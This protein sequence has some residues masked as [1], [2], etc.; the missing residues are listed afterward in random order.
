MNLISLFLF[1]ILFFYN[2]LAIIPT[3]AIVS[4]DQNKEYLQFWPIV[5]QAWKEIIGIQ[6]TLLFVG[7]HDTPIEDSK[8]DV[9]RFEPIPDIPTPYQA[10]TIR[11]L[12]P[13]FFPEDIC[14]I[15]D[16]DMLPLDKS[17]FINNILT[18]I[19][20]DH[21]IIYRAN[22]IPKQFPMCY[23]AGKGTTYKEIFNID[24]LENISKIIQEW[25]LEYNT[26]DADQRILYDY[27]LKWHKYNT[28]CN[29][30]NF[31]VKRID[32]S[33][34]HYNHALLA[35]GNYYTD[36]HCPRPY[37]KYKKSIDKI[38]EILASND[39]LPSSNY[40]SPYT[41][42]SFFSLFSLSF[43]LF[44][45]KKKSTSSFYNS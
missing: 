7:P 9:I 6:P 39:K 21:F 41:L 30:F 34:W 2:S 40:P 22:L 12:A 20:N 33:N 35:K 16:I 45:S 32:R 8:G 25:Y 44:V 10:M 15:S 27:T 17:Y 28:H 5:A 4:S 11:L 3:R 42:L 37:R 14:I 43:Y 1:T 29:T 24:C 31:G 18:G 36:A 19:A 23:V 26:F 13:A 38:I